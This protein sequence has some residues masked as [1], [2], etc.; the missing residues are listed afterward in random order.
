MNLLAHRTA[1]LASPSIPLYNASRAEGTTADASPRHLCRNFARKNT[2]HRVK[3]K[4]KMSVV[5][6]KKYVKI[7]CY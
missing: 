4:C 2:S 1:H 5:I 3:Y 6:E 7:M